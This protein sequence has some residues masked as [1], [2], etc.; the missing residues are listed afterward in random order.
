MNAQSDSTRSSWIDIPLHCSTCSSSSSVVDHCSWKW[1]TSARFIQTIGVLRSKPACPASG[2]VNLPCNSS[3][4]VEHQAHASA[5][6]ITLPRAERLPIDYR[7][8]VVVHT[9]CESNTDPR[10]LAW[11]QR[12]RRSLGG[13]QLCCEFVAGLFS[14]LQSCCAQRDL[15]SHA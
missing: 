5:C 6:R 13:P 15:F 4:P 11:Y 12:H 3:H 8:L 7:L 14:T 1:Q 9:T 2:Y 10:V